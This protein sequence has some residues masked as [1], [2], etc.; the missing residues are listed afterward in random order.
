MPTHLSTGETSC[1]VVQTHSARSEQAL[2][3]GAGLH[4]HSPQKERV[5]YTLLTRFRATSHKSDL[6]TIRVQKGYRMLGF[7]RHR[8]V[9]HNLSKNSRELEPVSR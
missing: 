9:S 8:Q 5:E 4:R 6:E 1:I 2:A 7:P 3:K